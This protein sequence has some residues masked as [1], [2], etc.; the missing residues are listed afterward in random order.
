MPLL[1]L[2]CLAHAYELSDYA[3]PPDQMPLVIHWT[4]SQPGFTHEE[5]TEAIEGAAAAWT[6][7]GPC[8]LEVVA[9]EDE[10]ADAHYEAGGVAVYF[11]DPDDLLEAGTFFATSWTNPGW[12]AKATWGGVDYE[13]APPVE[14]VVN[15][16]ADFLPD[17]TIEAG[18]C[19]EEVSL[20]SAL[21]SEIG[22]VLGLGHS[23][24]REATMHPT[25]S[26]CDTNRSTLAPDDIE[27]LEAI[28]GDGAA[29]AFNG[30]GRAVGSPGAVGGNG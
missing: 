29:I 6:Q 8:A 20:Q 27:G 16:T 28:Y 18:G 25:L 1:A 14:I 2:A 26:N 19:D 7:A 23:A 15:D 30:G 11:G 22:R 5:L 13:R 4:G 10:E 9:I 3:W 21:T 17:A 12:A 24:V